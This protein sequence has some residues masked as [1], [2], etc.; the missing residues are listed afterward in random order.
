MSDILIRSSSKLLE[1]YA[2]RRHIDLLR[3][4][5]FG[6]LFLTSAFHVLGH[7]HRVI[8]TNC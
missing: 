1:M 2:P 5:D 7:L 3:M 8:F 6:L 4:S